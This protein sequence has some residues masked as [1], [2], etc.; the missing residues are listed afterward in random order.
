MDEL[1]V[2]QIASEIARNFLARKQVVLVFPE[3]N[4]AL[5]QKA[6]SMFPRADFA[7]S[8]KF[9]AKSG[10]SEVI[11]VAPSL[12]F[13]SRLVQ[14][15]TEHPIVDFIVKL[16]YDGKPV[17]AMLG[18][19]LAGGN[20]NVGLFKA[21]AEMRDRLKSFGIEIINPVTDNP[22]ANSSIDREIKAQRL[23][24]LSLLQTPR[25]DIHPSR[26]QIARAPVEEFLEFLEDRQC[27]IEK[28]KPCDRCDMCSTLGF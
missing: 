25:N 21:I 24:S 1:A 4:E 22:A 2:R 19:M 20:G 3:A 23:E 28:G 10:Y 27:I 17:R 7:C 15:Q 14:L 26:L 11:L 18:G 12:D 13:V 8:D 9:E 5:K 6:Q 16:L